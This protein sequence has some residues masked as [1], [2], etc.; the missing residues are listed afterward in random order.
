MTTSDPADPT[1]PASQAEV[2][3]SGERSVAVNAGEGSHVNVDN[4][5]GIAVP[6]DVEAL[7]QITAHPGS[8]IGQIIGKQV[9]QQPFVPGPVSATEAEIAAA[10]T[11]LAAL[12]TDQPATTGV[13]AG[14][15]TEDREA[16]RA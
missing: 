7:Q 11:L 4:S 9:I 12:P 1:S 15:K 10:Q 5:I 14:Q 13:N 16:V 8:T 6:G 3:A 2:I